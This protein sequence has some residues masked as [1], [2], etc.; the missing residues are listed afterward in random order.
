[1][2]DFNISSLH[3]SKN[4][5]CS[6]LLVILTPQIIFGFRSIFEE[7]YQ[8]CVKNNETNKYLMTFQ[9]FISRIPKWSSTII[10]TEKNRII[11]KSNCKYLEDLITC[12]HIIQLKLLSAARAGQK[13]KKININIPNIDAFI[14]N[15]YINSARKVYTNVYLFEKQPNNPLLVQK[16]MRELEILVQDCILNTVRESIPVEA[17]LNAYM[18]ESMEEDIVED[19]K[20]E[21]V[22]E[23]LLDEDTREPVIV[24]EEINKDIDSSK[25]T[26]DTTNTT[27]IVNTK[28]NI[29]MS[30]VDIPNIISNPSS[31][32]EKF[33]ELRNNQGLSFNDIDVMRDENN[34]DSEVTVSKDV[35]NL[36]KISFQRSLERQTMDDDDDDNRLKI[37]GDDASGSLSFDILS[38]DTL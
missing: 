7:A 11:E 10:E 29:S 38:A 32:Q 22:H 26:N 18:D 4:E 21:I 31:E 23:E 34:I 20:E 14:H 24:T 33:P 17:I 28:N 16:N 27:N 30:S 13:Q 12:V 3:E 8:L 9:N 35:E 19:I 36:E 25:N 5:W 2:D 6:R 37:F 15:V 1:M